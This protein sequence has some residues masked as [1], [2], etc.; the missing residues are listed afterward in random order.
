MRAAALFP[1]GFAATMPTVL[2]RQPVPWS[3][4][5]AALL[6]RV[7]VESRVDRT[8]A[9]PRWVSYLE[10]WSQALTK[11]LNGVLG[12]NS[13][14]VGGVV[15][16]VELAALILAGVALVLLAYWLVRW[17]ARRSV[18]ETEALP[19]ARERAIETVP[20]V[21]AQ[22]W[23]ATLEQKLSS[24]DASGALPALWW[25]FARSVAGSRVDESWT[26]RELLAASRRHDL[27]EEVMNLDRMLY[28]ARRPNV[29]Q[30]RDLFGQLDKAV[31]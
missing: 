3:R 1:A 20:S 7:L 26:S 29:D 28:G 6:G 17:I 4:A 21:T 22:E 9:G 31:A 10:A 27:R 19:P 12:R 30:V 2:E 14:M 13:G 24:G 5:D 16:G 23:R 15:R 11:W 25:W 18:S 8:P